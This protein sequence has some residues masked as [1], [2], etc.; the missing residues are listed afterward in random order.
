M[1]DDVADAWFK[2]F[3][4][5]YENKQCVHC[6]QPWTSRHQIGACVYAE[7]CGHRQYQGRLSKEETP[8]ATP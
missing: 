1:N 7:P 2:D 5:R 6:G 4:A 3:L 8:H